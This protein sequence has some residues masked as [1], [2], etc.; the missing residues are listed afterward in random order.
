MLLPLVLGLNLPSKTWP[1]LAVG[2]AFAALALFVGRRAWAGHQPNPAD[3][4]PADRRKAPRR[5]GGA[6]DV[7]LSDADF[8]ADVCSAEVVDRSV[9]G[10]KLLVPRPWP[11]GALLGVRPIHPPGALGAVVQV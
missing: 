5:V 2:M 3:T 11:A 9:D 7:V 4:V 8:R 1:A 10:L 6:V